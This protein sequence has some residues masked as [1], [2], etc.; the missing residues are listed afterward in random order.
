MDLEMTGLDP[1]RHGIVEIATLLT[2]DELRPIAEG[3]D[4]VVHA[5]PEQLL[6]MDDVVRSMHAR[7]GL[8]S[9]IRTST[10]SLADAGRLTLEF[11]RA[12]IGE[13]RSVPLCGNSIG[14][15]RRF[16]AAYLPEVDDFLHYRSVDVSSVKELCRRWYPEAYS[17]APAKAET[18]RALDD[19]R[20]SIAELG[21]YRSTIFAGSGVTGSA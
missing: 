20:E 10:M 14:T 3:P 5:S 8:L 1:A 21:Y 17:R 11:L 7:S 12:H 15:D 16:L 6:E 19:I 2:D 4:I 9:A 13:P 18:H